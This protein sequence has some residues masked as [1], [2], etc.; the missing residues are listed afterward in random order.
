MLGGRSAQRNQ[1]QRTPERAAPGFPSLGAAAGDQLV[2]RMESS[3]GSD[4]KVPGE[5]PTSGPL[6]EFAVA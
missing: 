4:T 2:L 6:V 3:I 5:P 1:K